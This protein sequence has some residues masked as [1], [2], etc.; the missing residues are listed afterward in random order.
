M[1]KV[2]KI[3]ILVLTLAVITY[4]VKQYAEKK[5]LVAYFKKELG[6]GE[7]YLKKFSA[8][9]L[10]TIYKYLNEY[11]RQQRKLTEDSNPNLFRKMVLV[12]RKYNLFPS[13]NS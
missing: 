2:L 13:F 4:F 12:N 3:I 5:R 9:E 6:F 10:K 8:D 1:S 11:S 7:G